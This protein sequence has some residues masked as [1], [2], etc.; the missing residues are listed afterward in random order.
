MKHLKPNLH[1][2]KLKC[3]INRLT[4]KLK[5]KRFNIPSEFHTDAETIKQS[6]WQEVQATNKYQNG[7]KKNLQKEAMV[8]KICSA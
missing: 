2:T 6:L 8:A 1:K 7:N 5:C 4:M 3:K